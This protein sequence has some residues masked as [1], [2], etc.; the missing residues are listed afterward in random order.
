MNTNDLKILRNKINWENAK[1]DKI[2]DFVHNI[3]DEIDKIQVETDNTLYQIRIQVLLCDIC[4]CSYKISTNRYYCK[5][6]RKNIREMF[7][8]CDKIETYL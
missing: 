5:N 2:V 4:I 8:I 7:E 1:N 3:Q 6:V